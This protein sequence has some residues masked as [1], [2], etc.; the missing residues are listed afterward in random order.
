[1]GNAEKGVKQGKRQ[2]PII[3]NK[4]EIR[5]MCEKV[6]NQYPLAWGLSG[7]NMTLV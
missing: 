6:Y 3:V 4:G 1:M 2:L 7:V 5:Q